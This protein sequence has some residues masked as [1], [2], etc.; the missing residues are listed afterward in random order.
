MRVKPKKNPFA[1]SKPDT[2]KEVIEKDGIQDFYHVLRGLKWD[3]SKGV[4][5]MDHTNDISDLYAIHYLPT[6]YLIDKDGNIIGKF[7]D[8]ALDAKL[9]EI[10][11]N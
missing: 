3:R 5:G 10:F 2:W 7:E 1:D 9:K 4:D 6:K 11:G 8:E